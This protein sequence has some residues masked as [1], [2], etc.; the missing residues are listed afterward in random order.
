[1]QPSKS[2]R[3]ENTVVQGG[4]F[5]D[6]TMYRQDYVPKEVQP[7][8]AAIIDQPTSRYTFAGLDS[9]GH[10]TYEPVHTSI[11]PL[12]PQSPMQSQQRLAMS[13]A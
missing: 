6:R 2:F 12:Q 11:R 10:K 4:H 3:P 8:P 7:C 5:E 1:M 13:V 9:R